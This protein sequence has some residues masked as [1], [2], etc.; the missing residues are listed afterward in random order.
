MAICLLCIGPAF[1]RGYEDFI[2]FYEMYGIETDTLFNFVAFMYYCSLP[3]YMGLGSVVATFL[4]G[5]FIVTA[6]I[7]ALFI[8]LCE[9]F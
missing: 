4:L 2:S 5:I 6:D 9:L 1:F 3:L 8:S 7:R